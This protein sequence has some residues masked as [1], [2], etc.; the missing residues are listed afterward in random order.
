[1]KNK[2]FLKTITF[3][4]TA[5]FMLAG[6]GGTDKNKYEQPASSAISQENEV[7]AEKSKEILDMAGRRVKVPSEI[8]KA[9]AT[10]QIGIIAL[11]T[12]NPD[13]LAGWGFALS[14]SDKQFISEK[15]YELPVLGVWSGKNGTGNVEEIIK[16]HPDIIFS[17]GTID[18]SQKDLSDKIQ[19]QTG[20][21]VVMLDAPLEKL[22]IMY[23]K[24][25]DIMGEKDRAK[26]LGD[27]CAKTIADINKFKLK[28]PHG[29][30]LKVYY[31]EG[32]KGLETD[33]KGSFHTEVLDFAGGINVAEVPKQS[34]FGRSAVSLEQLLKWNPEVIVVGYDKDAKS[35]FFKDIYTTPE[36]KSIKAVKD[37]KVYA[38]PNKPFDWFDRP[39]SVNRILGV[40]WLANLLYPEYVN[41]NID[42]EVKDFYDKFYHKKLTEQEVKNLLTEARGR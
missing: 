21:P 2:V 28:I 3:I 7:K 39:P 38:I 9:Y 13:K 8:K 32:A 34:G 5:A 23:E 18:S 19:V 17:I 30:Q 10:S 11:Y 26:E 33:P 42:N 12:L 4:L 36:W 15:Y 24:L 22:D 25:G 6:C 31:A 40:K 16:V 27:Y 35:G 1:M 29:K 37:K 20:I 14:E 41:L